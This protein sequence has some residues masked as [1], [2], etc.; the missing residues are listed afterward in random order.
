MRDGEAVAALR[1][2]EVGDIDLVWGEPGTGPADGFGLAKIARLHPEVLDDLQG[3]LDGLPV[4][5]RSDNRVRFSDG[6]HFAAVSLNFRGTEKVWL[7]T[8]FRRGAGPGGTM[9]G[10]GIAGGP[11]SSSTTGLGPDIGAANAVRNPAGLPDSAAVPKRD[12]GWV[13]RLEAFAAEVDA[14]LVD[15]R[16]RL[17]ALDM[18]DLRARAA[19]GEPG[20]RQLAD[21]IDEAEAVDPAWG[22]MLACLTEAV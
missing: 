3:I 1:H 11:T 4:I 17:D 12:E 9:D 21:L 13:A 16:A 5:S 7:L 10:A 15:A 8:A 14:R 19:G 20:A 18:D 6:E 22:A 2:R